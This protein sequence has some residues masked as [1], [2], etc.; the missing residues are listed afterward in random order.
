MKPSIKKVITNYFKL[1]APNQNEGV[2]VTY[3]EFFNKWEI[4]LVCPADIFDGMRFNDQ[5]KRS[6]KQIERRLKIQMKDMFPY[7]F[8]VI[9]IRDE[10]PI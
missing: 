7:N 2:I 10:R 9:I 8:D 4:V 3:L 6:L 5:R 1:I